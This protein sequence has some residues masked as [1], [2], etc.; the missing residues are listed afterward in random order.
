MI[1]ATKTIPQVAQKDIPVVGGH[2]ITID[3]KKLTIDFQNNEA[4]AALT[5]ADY[6]YLF[7]NKAG[8]AAIYAR[9]Y[10]D[11]KNIS[12]PTWGDLEPKAT[13]IIEPEILEE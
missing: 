9:E 10:P 11:H 6:D 7:D 8:L 3:L 2:I 12:V 5:K 4:Q 13:P 1:L